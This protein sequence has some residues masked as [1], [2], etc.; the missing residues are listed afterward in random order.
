M[1]RRYVIPLLSLVGTALVVIGK[2]IQPKMAYP[3]SFPLQ[4][5]SQKTDEITFHLRDGKGPFR[6]YREG[7]LIYEGE[8]ESF[9]DSGLN[10]GTTYLYTLEIGSR[11]GNPEVLKVQTSTAVESKAAENVLQD[12]VQTTIISQSFVSMEW[13]PIDGVGEYCIYRNGK[14]IAKVK[15]PFFLD[16]WVGN[17]NQYTYWIH[18]ERSMTESEKDF[19][20]EKFL[21][22]GLVGLF[23]KSTKEA[24]TEKY[25]I[26]KVLDP[27]EDILRLEEEPDERKEWRFLYKTFLDKKWVKNPN[28]ASPYRYFK[29]DGRGFDPSAVEYRTMAE[30]VVTAD[31]TFTDVRL[32]KD[33]G[34]TKGYGL[35]RNLKNEETASD[36]GI[37]LDDTEV[38]ETKVSFVLKHSVGNPLVNSPAI[39]YHVWANFYHNGLYDIVGIHDQS[40]NHEIYLKY[41]TQ[42]TWTTLH[43]SSS[44]GLEWMAEPMPAMYWRVC[45]I[46]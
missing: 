34:E 37:Q 28:V 19:D 13:D 39:D 44:E 10:S 38:D 25:Q 16:R 43:Q 14:R 12:S 2:K 23:K 46:K 33:V 21:L 24:V 32:N 1:L 5:I 29:G 15:E 42:R 18:A 41:G 8:D 40:P 4:K 35:L 26:T 36:E 6:I 30:V 7:E 45:N 17:R 27:L 9:T 11:R 31:G 22:A 3:K 20:E